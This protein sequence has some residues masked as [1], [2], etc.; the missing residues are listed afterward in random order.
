MCVLSQ[1]SA[2]IILTSGWNGSYVNWFLNNIK[3]S[4]ICIIDETLYKIISEKKLWFLVITKGTKKWNVRKTAS[5]RCQTCR[6]YT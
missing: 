5:V 6:S 2:C 1:R 3:I 4:C